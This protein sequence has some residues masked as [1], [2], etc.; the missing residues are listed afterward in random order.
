MRARRRRAASS[1]AATVQ[2]LGQPAGSPRAAPPGRLRHPGAVGLRRPHRAREPALLRGRPRRTRAA[3]VDRVVDEVGP[4]AATPTPSSAGSPAASEPGSRSPPR[5]SATPE[6]L[7]LDEPTVGLDPVLRRDLWA[8]FHD[9]AD[10]RHD[11]AGLQPRHGRG[12]ALRP[13]A[14]DARGRGCSPTTPRRRCSPAPAPRTS[15][16]RSSPSWTTRRADATA[17]RQPGMSTRRTAR[18]RA[19]GPAPAAPRPAHHR[20]AARRAVRADRPARAGS[21]TAPRRSTRSARRCSASSR[22][23]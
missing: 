19:P 2:V 8:L 17:T 23:S 18:H 11:P 5:C 15:R 21:S 20:A 7:V 1:R 6:L 12:R 3:D 22:S 4:R 10:A 9:L 13:P 14:A 16:P